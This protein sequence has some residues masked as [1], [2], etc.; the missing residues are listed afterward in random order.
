MHLRL[1]PLL[2]ALVVVS[3]RRPQATPPPARI[4]T[5]TVDLRARVDT[6]LI[7]Q[8]S[9]TQRYTH[10]RPSRLRVTPDGDAVLFLRTPQGSTSRALYVW[11][12]A[13][14]T[15]RVLVSAE[16]LLSG[17]EETLSAEE[18][19]RRER[20]RTSGRGI[21]T[22]ELSPDGQRVLVPLSGRLYIVE[23]SSGASRVLAATQGAPI[24]PRL[25]PD[26]QQVAYVRAGEL[27]VM[28][29]ATGTERVLTTG[30]TATLTHGVA[31]FIA[32][33]EL[34]RMEGYWWSPDGTEIAWQETDLSRVERL[35]ISDAAHPERAPDEPAYPRAGTE[36]A[37]VRIGITPVAGGATRW[38]TWDRARYPYLATVRWTRNAPLTLVVLD[39]VQHEAV[40]LAANPDG[41][42]RTLHQ[43]RDD[44]WVNIDPS[45]PLW[46]DDGAA[47]FW[48]TER[49]GT[50]R[51]ER[52]S[53][54]GEAA[55]YVTP[56]AIN[57]RGLVRYDASRSA[58][59]VRAGEEPSETHLARV[60]VDTGTV[61]WL[62]R[63]PAEYDAVVA[64]RG[65]LHVR[66]VHALDAMPRFTVHEADGRELGV[67]ASHAEAL[68]VRPRVEVKTVGAEGF[69]VA[70]VR[71]SHYVASK[72]YPVLV[73]VYGGPH[74][75]LVVHAMERY[76]TQQWLAEQGFVVVIADGRGTLARGRTWERAL[77][78]QLGDVPLEDQVRALRALGATDPSLDLSRV[79]VIGWSFGGY[80][81][82][83][84]VID[85]PDVFHAA[86][87]G[88]PV[89]DWREYDTCYTER[90]LGLPAEH[91][92]A[93]ARASLLTHAPN[94]TRPLL[95]VHGTA[96]DNVYVHNSLKLADTL[97]MA[98]RRFEFLPLPGQTHLVFDAAHSVAWM[99]RA[100]EFFVT[101]LI[102][103]VR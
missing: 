57:L 32:Q 33:E 5:A 70:V 64:Q 93:Y 9:R 72:R 34:D 8:L 1:S 73:W 39:R 36:N 62:T 60:A 21:T 58:L 84:A 98:A 101:H 77:Y 41:S 76:A 87:A 56:A 42:T 54:R 90:Y 23:R 31:E 25:S 55:R 26:G 29:L 20:T 3:C 81:S 103:N 4:A 99:L 88:A 46:T 7:E 52:V 91:A 95:L 17:A 79:G 86:V 63:G 38:I 2:A 96:D 97:L 47:F 43:E 69:R 37:L 82:A 89:T 67:I 11:E 83:R 80:L 48:M 18:R 53:V 49:D 75:R 16:T 24:D 6:R 13:R 28:D 45:F 59:Y 102:E 71:P 14:N 27:A 94:L 40:V 50:R 100:R 74:S 61:E 78:M 35:R 66:E 51:I 15:E 85:R 44:A 19:A 10:G 22:Y 68:V 92:D 65:G 12:R 30:A